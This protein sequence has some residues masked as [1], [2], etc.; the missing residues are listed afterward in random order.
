MTAREVAMRAERSVKD[1]EEFLRK[2]AQSRA[3]SGMHRVRAHKKSFSPLMPIGTSYV[4][5]VRQLMPAVPETCLP[6]GSRKTDA[7]AS[8]SI[9]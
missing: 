2:R 9:N 5:A 7:L 8:S 6:R 1:F 3:R 4:R